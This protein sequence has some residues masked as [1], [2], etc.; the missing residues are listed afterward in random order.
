[1]VQKIDWLQEFWALLQG[2]LESKDAI[3][4][5]INNSKIILHEGVGLHDRFADTF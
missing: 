3:F 1:M 2:Y 5:M 4:E